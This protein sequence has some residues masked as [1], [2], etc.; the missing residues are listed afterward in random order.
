M[1]SRCLG[2]GN[3]CR[4]GARCI[5]RY[6]TLECDCY[7]THNEGD[8]CDYDSEPS[9]NSIQS[10][11]SLIVSLHAIRSNDGDPARL[12]V[13]HVPHLRLERPGLQRLQP[14]QPLLPSKTTRSPFFC[15]LDSATTEPYDQTQVLMGDS[16]LFYASGTQP[17]ENH[18]AVTLTANGS[19]YV[20]VD[21]GRGPHGVHLGD[22][23]LTNGLWN[24]L[25]FIHDGHH[26]DFLLNGKGPR[27][28]VQGRSFFPTSSL[29]TTQSLPFQVPGRTCV[30]SRTS[31]SAAPVRRAAWVSVPA[32]TWSAAYPRSVPHSNTI[33]AVPD[34]DT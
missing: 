17:D 21:F 9:F 23:P 11:T 2:E 3:P 20:E 25:T 7:G 1:C 27:L 18:V 6:R 15:S 34:V 29:Q 19:L 26:L 31:S 24:N 32:T 10:S 14:H 8:S 12:L 4:N 5:N 30:W 28:T 22:R 33:R 13:H 16:I